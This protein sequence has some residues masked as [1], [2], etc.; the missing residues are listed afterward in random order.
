MAYINI[1][2]A[3]REA[4]KTMTPEECTDGFARWRATVPFTDE[5]IIAALL[6]HAAR[7]PPGSGEA[8][9]H[10]FWADVVKRTGLTAKAYRR[11]LPIL[12]KTCAICGK[13]A[14]YRMGS[15]GRCSAHRSQLTR[16][17]VYTRDL[18]RQKSA[19]IE[20]AKKRSDYK[21]LAEARQRSLRKD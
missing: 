8:R 12:V 9:D 4:W 3:R 17:A 18:C 20:A 21:A 19:S 10:A 16:G 13:K 6:E 5:Q 11:A 14:L 15:E 1:R 2:Q 7:C